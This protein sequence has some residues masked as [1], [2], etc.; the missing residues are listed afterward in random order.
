MPPRVLS[1][2]QRQSFWVKR[3]AIVSLTDFDTK[4]R[5]KPHLVHKFQGMGR[6]LRE[7]LLVEVSFNYSKLNGQQ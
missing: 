2:S 3:Q 5:L 4:S 1:L 7:L 6:R